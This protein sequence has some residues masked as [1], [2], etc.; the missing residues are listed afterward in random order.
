M[1][2]FHSSYPEGEWSHLGK[3]HVSNEREVQSLPLVSDTEH[4]VYSKYIK[5]QEHL[6]GTRLLSS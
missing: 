4:S 3:F 6:P 5:V 1:V 2:R